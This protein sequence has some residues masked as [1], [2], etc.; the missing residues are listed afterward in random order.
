MGQGMRLVPALRTSRLSP[1]RTRWLAA[2]RPLLMLAAPLPAPWPV[3][4]VAGPPSLAGSHAVSAARGLCARTA[5]LCVLTSSA[6][7]SHSSSPAL[8][9]SLSQLAASPLSP[10]QRHS[11]KPRPQPP[12]GP[13]P[14]TVSVPAPAPDCCVE[15]G[16]LPAPRSSA[17]CWGLWWVLC[18]RSPG[19]GWSG[20]CLPSHGGLWSL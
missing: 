7:A 4:T 14:E 19:T 1:P 17:R 16:G 9:L 10:A 20:C 6:G 2:A 8:Q 18:A 13:Q 11:A 15:A 12:D 3:P 5:G